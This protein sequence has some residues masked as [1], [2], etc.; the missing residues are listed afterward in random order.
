MV[1]T[2]GL[3]RSERQFR[4]LF[5]AAGLQLA[6]IVPTAGMVSVLEATSRVALP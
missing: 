4:D 2:G 5:T 3:Q 1:A 6:R